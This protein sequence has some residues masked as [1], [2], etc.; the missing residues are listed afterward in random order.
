MF[1]PEL[2]RTV[3]EMDAPLKN[4]HSHR[5]RSVGADVDPAARRVAAVTDPVAHCPG[6]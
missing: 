2:G 3:A 6:S 5:A 1:I 4:L